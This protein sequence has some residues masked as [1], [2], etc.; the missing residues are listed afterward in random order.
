MLLGST[1]VG[2]TIQSCRAGVGEGNTVLNTF[3]GG[4]YQDTFSSRDIIIRNNYYRNVI[5]GPYLA[6]GSLSAGPNRVSLSVAQTNPPIAQGTLTDEQGNTINHGFAD[7]EPVN[8][9]LAPI[10]EYNLLQRV[11]TVVNPTTFTYPLLA[12]PSGSSIGRCERAQAGLIGLNHLGNG[13]AEATTGTLPEEGHGL[14]VG[15]RI[16]VINA[17]VSLTDLTPRPEYNG[18][19]EITAVLGTPKPTKFRYQMLNTPGGNAASA[20]F[21]RVWGVDRIVIENNV[22]ELADRK[23]YEW[24][25]PFGIWIADNALISPPPP[26]PHGEAIVRRN[27]VRYVDGIVNS[28]NNAFAVYV[29]GTKKALVSD[30]IVDTATAWQPNPITQARSQVQYF[31]NSS[32]D[33]ASVRGHNADT[34]KRLDELETTIQDATLLAI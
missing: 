23:Y 21:Q 27:V 26:Y 7:Q 11:V 5:V 16:K 1:S 22:I 4:T 25:T 9:M 17:T 10:T 24:G 29:A 15:D 34:G 32:A 14:Q 2:F 3:Y 31:N 6:L 33:G 12:V 20:S 30:N 19:F 18:F 28:D 8:V 13:V